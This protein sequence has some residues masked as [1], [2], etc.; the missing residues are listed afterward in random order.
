VI[1]Q[2][3][4]AIAIELKNEGNIK[5]RE[6]KFHDALEAYTSKN[7]R[8]FFFLYLCLF[9]RRLKLVHPNQLKNFLNSIKIVLQLGNH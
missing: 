4:L 1:F 2:S 6:Q 5:Y 3:R 8:A 7:L 9:Q